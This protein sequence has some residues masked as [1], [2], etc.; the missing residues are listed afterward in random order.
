[1]KEQILDLLDRM[2]IGF[3]YYEYEINSELQ[4]A[5]IDDLIEVKKMIE[6]LPEFQI[7]DK[8]K[9][10]G[11]YIFNKDIDLTKEYTIANTTFIYK[12]IEDYIKAIYKSY[13]NKINI[14]NHYYCLLFNDIIN[15]SIDKYNHYDHDP[16]KLKRTLFNGYYFT[17]I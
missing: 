16:E 13:K 12:S 14:I 4:C 17:K 15:D 8:V 11:N 10:N 9:F 3:N 1:M 2:I 5:S 6:S 7:G